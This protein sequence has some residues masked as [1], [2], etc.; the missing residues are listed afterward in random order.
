M[1]EQVRFVGR[2]AVAA[3]MP[4]IVKQIDLVERTYRELARGRVEMP[5]KIGIHPRPDAF[6]HA[7]PAYLADHDVV[8]MKWVSGFPENPGRGL[9]YISGLILVN[10]A[11]TGVPLAVL[12]AAEITA[13]RTAAASGVCVRRWAPPGWARAAILGCGEQG[14]YH[15][16][17]LRELA[18]GCEIRAY[19][20]VSER[21]L[22]VCEGAVVLDDPRE[23]AA[24]AAVIVTAGPIVLDP[25]RPLDAGWLGERQLLLPID[26]DFY[27]S[28]GAVE[29]CDLTLT[30]DLAQFEEYRGHG[31]FQGWPA[32]QATV[33]EAL[34]RDLSG[35]RVVAANL[36]VGA[37]DAA[38][39]AEVLS[40]A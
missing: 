39:A 29:A 17:M 7:M 37:L 5:P 25:A 3:A 19:D 16:A 35:A 31:H 24:G 13:A 22:G 6:L 9:P 21:A 14:R 2:A 10:D 12:D 33:G 1:S 23:A 38:F 11:E 8:A 32:L 26:F 36:G 27:V 15:A 18:P 34:E 20:P 4:P 40:R 28:P 30:D